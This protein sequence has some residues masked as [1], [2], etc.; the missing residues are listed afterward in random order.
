M[1]KLQFI[2]QENEGMSHLE[3]I[4]IAC[5]AGVKWVQLRVKDKPEDQVLPVALEAK[6]ICERYGALLTVNDFPAVAKAVN[7][8]GIHLGR[9]DMPLQE[10]KKIAE[11]Q[12]AGGTANTF[13]DIRQYVEQGADYVGVGPYR[14]TSTKKKLSPVLGLEG[15]RQ[16]IEKCRGAGFKIPVLAI[17]GLTLEDIEGLI[18]TGVFGIAVSSLVVH[19]P[20]PEEVV[21]KIYRILKKER[22]LLC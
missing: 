11:K 18:Q 14:F 2:S 21:E 10:A 8:Y 12:I 16:L 6:G 19:A 22:S 17:G 1:E 13:E 15:Y 7:A 3:S 5:E 9:E 20:D 4:R